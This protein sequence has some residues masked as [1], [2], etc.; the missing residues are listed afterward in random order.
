MKRKRIGEPMALYRIKKAAAV[1]LIFLLTGCGAPPVTESVKEEEPGITSMEEE[2]DLAYEV[3]VSLPNILVN[4]LGYITSGTKAAVFRGEELPEEF[5]VIKE[6]T[7]ETVFIGFLEEEEQ[8][9]AEEGKLCYGDF[10]ALTTPGAYYLEAPLLGRSYTFQVA[11]DLYVQLLREACRQY[12]YN[13]CGMSLTSEFA[14]ERAH[15]ACHIGNAAL[16]E[17]ISVSLDVSG[18]WHQ[19][20]AGSKEVVTAAENIGVMLLAYE[21]YGGAFGDDMGI[22]ESGNEIPDIL[23]E[24]RYEAEWLLKMQDPS[25]GAVYRGVTVYEQGAG[26]GT[27]SYVEPADI[28]SA[29][30]FASVL[31]KFSYLYQNYEKT[32]AT[33]CLKAADRAWK[34]V[35]LNGEKEI[36]GADPWKFAAAAELYRASGLSS[37]RRYIT[38][39]LQQTEEE[40]DFDEVTF[41]GYVTYISTKQRVNL[42]LCEQITK[43]LMLKAEE[44]SAEARGSA[45]LVKEGEGNEHNLKLLRNMMYL[46]MVD[47]MISNHEYD[48]VIENHLHYLMGRNEQ[49]VCYIENEGN[50]YDSQAGETLGIMKQFEA[51]SRLIFML[52]EIVAGHAK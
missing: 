4:Q 52:S 24:I 18:G 44:I 21:L 19:D 7:G 12:Y 38:E 9:P 27:L 33:D 2:P 1:G 31:A 37:C 25:S 28:E 13:R 45:Y 16:R 34:Y 15:N 32:F 10:S 40:S 51:N 50:N 8:E 26:N 36:S 48:I 3:P 6:E 43:E 42:E 49:A 23:D 41:L 5:Y 11:D 14:G 35:E 29:K 17:D 22:P 46:T 30:A 39:Y 20:E 47:Y